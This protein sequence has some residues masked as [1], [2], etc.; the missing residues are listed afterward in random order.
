[1][2]RSLTVAA[3]QMGPI[4]LDESRTSASARMLEM[5]REAFGGRKPTS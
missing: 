2:T 5:M 3:A 4:A 1:M